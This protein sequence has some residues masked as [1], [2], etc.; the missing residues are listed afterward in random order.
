ML[1]IVLTALSLLVLQ[2]AMG[3]LAAIASS[4]S[5]RQRKPTEVMNNKYELGRYF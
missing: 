3:T 2:T 1:T 5:R 4:E